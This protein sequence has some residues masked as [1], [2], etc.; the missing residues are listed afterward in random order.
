MPDKNFIKLSF[1]N[2][3]PDALKQGILTNFQSAQID[4]QLSFYDSFNEAEYN[5]EPTA[6]EPEISEVI[7]SSYKRS[8]TKGQRNLDLDG[9][10]ASDRLI[11]RQQQLTKKVD[12]YKPLYYRTKELRFYR[13]SKRCKSQRYAIQSGRNSEGKWCKHLSVS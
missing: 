12:T 5:Q 13:V 1:R 9:L 7:I 11:Q 10:P 4:G 8:K 6:E 2:G 3:L